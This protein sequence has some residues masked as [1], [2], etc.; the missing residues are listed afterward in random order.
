MI[1]YRNDLRMP[2]RAQG[3]QLRY[4][5]FI[6]PTYM[7]GV[8]FKGKLQVYHGFKPCMGAS[9]LVRRHLGDRLARFRERLADISAYAESQCPM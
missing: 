8:L 6:K 5:E 4:R 3:R 2:R 9:R 7:G 1:C